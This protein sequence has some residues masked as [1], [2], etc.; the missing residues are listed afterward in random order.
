MYFTSKHFFS[1]LIVYTVPYKYPKIPFKISFD[2]L[3]IKLDLTILTYII[4]FYKLIVVI[5]NDS[6]LNTDSRFSEYYV[7]N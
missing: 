5:V 2:L 4:T 3:Y 7:L 1:E 6:I